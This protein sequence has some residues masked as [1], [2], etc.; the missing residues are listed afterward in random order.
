MEKDQIEL[1]IEEWTQKHAS[2]KERQA[3]TNFLRQD[4]AVQPNEKML[5]RSGCHQQFM[6]FLLLPMRQRNMD[7][8][9]PDE[10]SLFC[11]NCCT[12]VGQM[13]HPGHWIHQ[14]PHQQASKRK[15]ALNQCH[16]GRM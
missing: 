8:Y 4:F 9:D 10:H 7:M 11:Y 5:P 6:R 2:G 3:L 15:K 16:Y 14:H 1:W 13:L 12:E